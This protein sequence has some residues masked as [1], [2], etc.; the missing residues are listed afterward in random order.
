MKTQYFTLTAACV[1]ASLLAASAQAGL[2]TSPYLFTDQA[3]AATG[4]FEWD[5]FEGSVFAPFAPDAASAGVGSAT[6]SAADSVAQPD[7]GPPFA[8]VTST[9]NIYSGGTLIDWDLALTGLSTAEAN[10]TV[11]LQ[12][13]VVGAI[14]PDS[15]LLDGLAPV[16]VIDRGV[17]VDVAHNTDEGPGALFDTRYYWVEWQVAADADYLLEF[18]HPTTHTSFAQLRV[19]YFNTAGVYDAAAAGQAPEPTGALLAAL[20]GCVASL[21]GRRGRAG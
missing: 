3:A 5:E 20:A 1:A 19:N 12:L 15:L 11:V 6:A 8:L 13:G 7:D 18:T 14:T 9:D 10:T 4:H 17:A 2:E 16:E 21:S